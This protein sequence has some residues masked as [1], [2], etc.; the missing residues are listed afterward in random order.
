VRRR[1]RPTGDPRVFKSGGFPRW[2]KL[3]IGAAVVVIAVLIVGVIVVL[4]PS[5]PSQR[6]TP[7]AVATGPATLPS[8]TTSLPTAQLPVDPLPVAPSPTTT[9][10]PPA[11]PGTANVTRST[12]PASLTGSGPSPSSTGAGSGTGSPQCAS[13][14]C[15]P[16]TTVVEPHG[17]RDATPAELSGIAADFTAPPGRKVVDV[18][19]AASDPTWA[20]L[21]VAAG[22]GQ[23]QERV[24]VH[25][26]GG[27]W[28]PVES[29]SPQVPCDRALPGNV[30]ADLGSSMASCPP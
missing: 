7:I 25:Q 8:P 4:G 30:M 18:K 13:I 12:V 27:V 22:G 26:S 9:L 14:P 16:P 1:G 20:I 23:P 21:T 11:P 6:G 2:A 3:G 15:D 19:I 28:T 24:L 17:L 5:S 29:G 10:G